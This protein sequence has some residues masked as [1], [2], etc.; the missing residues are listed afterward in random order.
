MTTLLHKYTVYKLWPKWTTTTRM[1]PFSESL[2]GNRN[3]F[4]DILLSNECTENNNMMKH[5]TLDGEGS[6][7]RTQRS[8]IVGC[9]SIPED[10]NNLRTH[11][12]KCENSFFRTIRIGYV[13][14]P[15]IRKNLKN[16]FPTRIHSKSLKVHT[17]LQTLSGKY[18]HPP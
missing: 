5:S 13:S 14:I 17:Y 11:T 8:E 10:M 18:F 7:K 16:K 4:L 9:N 6:H 12:H 3:P 15:L 2:C 1:F